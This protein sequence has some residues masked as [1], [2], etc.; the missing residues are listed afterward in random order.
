MVELGRDLNVDLLLQLLHTGHGAVRGV[1]GDVERVHANLNAVD[2]LVHLLEA[3][4]ELLDEVHELVVGVLTLDMQVRGPDPR[5][6]RGLWGRS[7]ITL[8]T[9][10]TC[11]W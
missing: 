10:G 4:L 2:F 5:V 8:Q 7:S 6:A 1:R 3:N 11:R 9:D